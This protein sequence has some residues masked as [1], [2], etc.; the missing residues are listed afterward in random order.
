[1][2][3]NT[4][5]PSRPALTAC[6]VRPVH[7]ARTVC[8]V[9][10]FCRIVCL[11]LLLIL[12]MPAAIVSADPSA[13]GPQPAPKIAVVLSGGSAFGIAHAGVLKKIEEAGIPIDMILGTSMGSIVGGLYAA[14]YSPQA[15]QDLIS[16]IDWNALFMDNSDRPE[17]LFHHSI[18]SKYLARI[19][20]DSKGLNIGT[21]L[22]EGQNI[23]AFF[24]AQTIHMAGKP[25]FDAFPVPY[26]SVAADILTGQKVVFDHGSLAEA[27]RCSMSIPVVFMPY[28]YKGRL[29]VDGGIVD[30]LPVNLARQI[31]AD[32][33]IAVISRGRRPSSLDELNSSVE[34]ASQTGNIFISQNMEPNIQAADLVIMPDLGDFTTAS[35][36]RAKEIIVQGEKAGDSAMPDLRELARKISATRPLVMP[37]NQPNRKALADPP[38]VASIR[39][40]G[41]SAE[42]RQKVAGIFASL[43]GRQ[44]T[45]EQLSAAIRAAYAAGDFSLVK[46]D[47]EQIASGQGQQSGQLGGVVTLVPARQPQ[48]E[49][50]GSLDFQ[51]SISRNISSDLVLSSGFLAK[52]ATGPGSA[53]FASITLVN[54]T[55]ASV[56]Y[57]Q[58]FGP[59]FILPWAS[60]RFEYDMFASESIPIALASKFRTVGGG[61]WGG[62][63]LGGKAEVMAGYSFENVLTGDDWTS[64]KALNAGALRAAFAVDTREKAV[65]AQK[66]LAL[67]AYGRWFSPNFGGE[68]AFAQAEV[69]AAAS[70]PVG[71][72]DAFQLNVFGGSDFAGIVAGAQ[73]AK[74]SYYA[75]IKQPGMFYG[76]GYVSSGCAGNSVVAGSLEFRHRIGVMNELVGG[77]I[78]L[79]ANGSIGAVA[80][81]DDPATY[82]LM[83][84]KWS[85]TIG[86]CAAVSKHYGVLAGM[87]VLGNID[88]TYALLP[89]LVI[90]LGSF[91]HAHVLDKR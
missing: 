90:Q 60:F 64:L 58:P 13:P 61:L 9:R 40:E 39:V 80:Q 71:R 3:A 12:A 42:E 37:E 30:N 38:L 54:R 31:G 52:E 47:L 23:L 68:F 91:S 45:R 81:L 6:T 41:V 15:M 4:V 63:A 66:G 44:Y 65:F 70:I 48:N 50:F 86:A 53:L 72:G 89:A 46:F 78:Y 1:M 77:D 34:I 88:D 17:H 83:P 7:S 59:F 73:P 57:F 74:I 19:G 28:E 76:M 24:T 49:L 16:D 62:L 14:G 85:A 27:M 22:L 2:K 56:G 11:A 18:E 84:L 87:S 69:S 33:V 82:D 36:A 10:P 67:S 5:S 25:S 51:S 20:F 79:F 8:T 75:S 55:S 29:L 43:A 32:I 26:R 35:Y 21:G